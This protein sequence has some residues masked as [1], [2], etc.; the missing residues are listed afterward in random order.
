[1]S[2][3]ESNRRCIPFAVKKDQPGNDAALINN[4]KRV[5]LVMYRI[6]DSARGFAYGSELISTPLS[7]TMEVSCP[8]VS[9]CEHLADAGNFP[10][11]LQVAELSVWQI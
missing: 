9:I 4:L 1:M 2:R 7:E 11:R 6:N 5:L 10:C 3:D 8:R